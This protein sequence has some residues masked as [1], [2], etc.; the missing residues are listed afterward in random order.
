MALMSWSPSLSVNIK[1][2]DDQHRKLVDMVNELHEAM[3]A[4]NGQELLGNIIGALIS[5]TVTHFSDEERLMASHA[6]PDM[7]AH[8]DE[9]ERLVRQV[10]EMQEQYAS[11]QAILTLELMLFLKDWLMKHIQGD[12]KKFGAYLAATPAYCLV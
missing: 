1:Q 10:L 12:D 2:F 8:K 9:H 7:A 4:G 5:Y 11:G 3:R 6:Y